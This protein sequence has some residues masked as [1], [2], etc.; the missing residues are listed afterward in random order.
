MKPANQILYYYINI[1]C[2][3]KHTGT[4]KFKDRDH[5]KAKA[6]LKKAKEVYADKEGFEVEWLPPHQTK[7]AK[8][9]L[10]Q[11]SG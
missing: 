6:W 1:Y 2:D 10:K 7:E 11:V 8:E 3:G 4:A 5:Y 9:L